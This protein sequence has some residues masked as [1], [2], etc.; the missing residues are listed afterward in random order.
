MRHDGSGG[1]R[2][3]CG[4][5]LAPTLGQ[6]VDTPHGPTHMENTVRLTAASAKSGN[7]KR[8]DWSRGEKKGKEKKESQVF[9]QDTSVFI[10]AQHFF[11]VDQSMS[12]L[13]V[14]YLEWR[15]LA[16]PPHYLVLYLR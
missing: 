5:R 12:K 1:H 2:K 15:T 6:E 14:V 3:A 13:E 7:L 16:V 9:R 4:E 8:E 10:T 11:L